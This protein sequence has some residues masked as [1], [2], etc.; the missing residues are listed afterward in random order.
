[1]ASFSS[2]KVE[3]LSEGNY[4]TWSARMQAYLTI[5]GMWKVVESGVSDSSSTELK[6][7]DAQALSMIIMGL[8]DELVL[9][10]QVLQRLN[11]Y[12]NF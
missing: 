2:F 4:A 7:K 6:E 5:N 12:G 1:M 8:G 9:W 10:P 3:P 11:N